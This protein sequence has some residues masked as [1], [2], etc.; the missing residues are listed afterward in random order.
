VKLGTLQ[1]DA[2]LNNLFPHTLGWLG[3]GVA[4]VYFPKVTA[5]YAF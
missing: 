1:L 3:S 4:Q 2:A 5:T